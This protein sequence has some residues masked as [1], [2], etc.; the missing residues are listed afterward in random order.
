MQYGPSGKSLGA[1]TVIFH[2]ADH[3]TKAVQALD[4][5]RIDNRLLKVE[6]LLS[7]KDAPAPTAQASLA[8][9][10]TYVLPQGN[11]NKKQKANESRSQPKKDKPKPATATKATTAATRGRGAGRRRGRGG[12]NTGPKKKTLEEL[13]AEMADYFPAAEGGNDAMVTN[14]N[15]TQAASGDTAMDDEML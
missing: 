5:I 3:A 10:V 15:T 7:A 6:I 2:K 13:D 9:R 1:A 8:D 12:R 4:N 14:G 11:L